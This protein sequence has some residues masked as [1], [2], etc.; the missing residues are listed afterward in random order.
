L[1][2]PYSFLTYPARAVN[3]KRVEGEKLVDYDVENER[4]R[5]T[6]LAV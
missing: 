6:L 3:V 4:F 2:I 5:F 1:A